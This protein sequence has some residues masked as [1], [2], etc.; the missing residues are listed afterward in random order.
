[1]AVNWY[2]DGVPRRDFLKVGTLTGLGV[3]LSQYLQLTALGAVRRAGTTAE[4][5]ILVYLQGGPSHMDTFD[6]KPEAPEQYRGE[7]RPIQ[8]K[9]PGIQICEHLPR[10]AA[11]ADKYTIVRGVSHT[12]AAHALGT[13]YVVTG[14][15]PLASLRF[16]GFGSVVSREKPAPPDV[17][18][19]V[20]I[21]NTPETAGYLGVRYS[22][23]QTNQTPQ[24]GRPFRVRGISLGNGLTVADI[25]RRHKLLRDL[26]RAFRSFE[27]SS[28]L[29]S[30][31]D[32]FSKQVYAMLTSRRCRDAFDLSKEPAT[33]TE[34]FGQHGFGQSCLLA[35]RLVEAGVR[36]VTVSNG[37]WDTHATNFQRLKD[38]LLPQLDE[39]VSALLVTLA[40]RGLLRKT[41]VIVLGEFGRTPKVNQRAG[42]D[43]WPRAMFVLLAGGPFGG[44]KV[45]GAS[46]EKGQ[47]PAE[48]AIS[49]DDI[50]AS[51]YHA[52]GIDHT[53]EYHTPTGRPVMIV[54]YGNVI[55]ELFA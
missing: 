22:P 45:V 23:F 43:H 36:F 44:G 8:T 15:R 14:N 21:P 26:D 46:D 28:S 16:P 3:S 35:V 32:A 7:F 24:P 41:V 12:V 4:S 37:G 53:K 55:P 6:M 34:R 13:Q 38:R 20:A 2:C 40:E 11:V 10:L 39:A 47:G 42:R 17:P 19:F 27:Q 30:G 9:V 54:R 31:L 1:M 51:L 33:V 52:L 29:L 18:A 5:A 50:A 49:P 48:R 25:E